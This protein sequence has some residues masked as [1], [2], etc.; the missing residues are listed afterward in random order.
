MPMTNQISRDELRGAIADKLSAHFGVMAE[1]ATDEQVF[2]AAAIVIREI[3]SRL[4][5]YE[6]AFQTVQFILDHIATF[7]L[8]RFD[9]GLKIHNCNLAILQVAQRG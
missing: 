4:C 3:L 6:L 7:T 2:Q 9:V 8:L 1:N 5:S